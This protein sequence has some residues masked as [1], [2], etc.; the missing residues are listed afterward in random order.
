VQI[1]VTG[2]AGYI[3]SVVT[4]QL[5]AEGHDVTIY[6]N[7]SEGH[8]ES[9]APAARLVRGD[10]RDGELIRETLRE[11]KIEAV[12]QMAAD[13]LVGESVVN[14]RKYYDNNLGGSISLLDAMIDCGVRKLVFS[15]T[16]AVYGAPDRV[17]ID[18]QNT[19]FPT[20]PYGETK[21]A[22]ERALKWY[23]NAYALRYASLRYFNAA[24]A[25]ERCGEHHRQETHLIPLVLQAAAGRRESVTIFGDDYATPDGTCIRDYV[26]VS[27][28]A[29]AHTLALGQLDNRSVVYNVGA[30]GAGYS[31]RQ[32]IDVARQVTGRDFKVEIGP[33]RPGDPPALV[34]DP[35]KIRTELGWRPARQD[36]RLIIE[37]AWRWMNAH[38]EGY[39]S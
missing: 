30:G 38:P 22:F 24:G 15:S 23:D 16:C 17:P 18:E 36:L 1:L 7:L 34:A 12:I 8:I 4:D 10:L 26:H 32:V 2:G 37:D 29:V 14:P 31:V 39:T 6:D 35:T 3:G 5:L 20:N 19:Q 25:T 28:L 9:I 21:L 27:D 33:R 11:G 13:A